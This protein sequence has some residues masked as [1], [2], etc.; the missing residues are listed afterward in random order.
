LEA[1]KQNKYIFLNTYY[2]NYDRICFLFHIL[3]ARVVYSINGATGKSFVLSL[4]IRLKKRVIFHW[5]GSDVLLAKEAVEKKTSD[6]KFLSYPVHLT[7]SPWFVDELKEIG[8]QAKYLPLLWVD[9]IPEKF[10]MSDEFSILTYVPQDDQGYYG[11]PAIIE[12]AKQFP[13]IIFKIAGSKETNL[14]LTPNIQLL[15]WIDNMK[16]LFEKSLVC[17]RFLKH[18]GL[19]FFVLESLLYGKYVIYNRHFDYCNYASN[20]QEM[21]SVISELYSKFKIGELSPNEDGR[22]FV[23]RE[24]SKENVLTL[25]DILTNI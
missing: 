13:E 11:L 5:V 15:G 8:I 24:F 18:D 25:A 7:D 20:V 17:I 19:S 12:V 4:A 9:N 21:I 23:I 1:D 2:S 10:V 3:T 22:E 14:P 6:G 16:P